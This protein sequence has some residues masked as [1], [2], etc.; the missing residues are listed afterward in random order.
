MDARSFICCP[1]IYEE[2]ALGILAVDN[3]KT[4]RPLFQSDISLLMGIT[5]EIGISI[6]NAILIEAKEHQ[7]RSL[8]Q[9]LAAAIYARDP[10]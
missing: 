9:V 3:V 4:K 7:F 6:H 8:L 2:K 5:P 1:I 10:P